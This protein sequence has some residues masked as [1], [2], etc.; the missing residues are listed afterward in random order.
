MSVAK[1]IQNIFTLSSVLILYFLKL[2]RFS[3]FPI[4]YLLIFT[5]LCRGHHNNQLIPGLSLLSHDP[6][7]ASSFPVE[8]FKQFIPAVLYEIEDQNIKRLTY[9]LFVKET[10]YLLLDLFSLVE[11]GFHSIIFFPT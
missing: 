11:S 1:I 2:R 5:P 9:F 8:L 7:S 4:K 3:L 6:F 10:Q